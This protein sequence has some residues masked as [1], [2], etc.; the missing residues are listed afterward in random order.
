MCKKPKPL[1]FYCKQKSSQ[2]TLSGRCRTSDHTPFSDVTVN[3]LYVTSE[4]KNLRQP[5]AE[6]PNKH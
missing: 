5:G 4:A 2:K 6:V 1:T 3:V